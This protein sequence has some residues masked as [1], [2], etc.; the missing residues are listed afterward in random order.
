[1]DCA[2]TARRLT[3]GEVTVFYRRTRKEMPAQDEELCDLLDEGGQLVE[4]AAPQR[5]EV[6]EGRLRGVVM[7]KMEL[8][9]AD[10]S[11]RRRPQVMAG[12]EYGVELDTLIVA[13]GQQPDLGVFS[14]LEVALTSS[15]FLDVDNETLETS[16]PGVYAGGDII[17][18][19]PVSIVK[20]AGDG[21]RIAEA[22]LRGSAS[23]PAIDSRTPGAWPTFDRSE[24][25]R[26]RA[27]V[28]PRIAVPHLSPAARTGFDEVI[29][30][31]TPE[32]AALEAARCLDCDVLCSTC[33]G[34]CPNRAIITYTARPALL[35][36]PTLAVDHVGSQSSPVVSFK[37]AQ[38]P[39]V[40]VLADACN[41]CGNC[42]TFCPTSGRPWLDKP[43]LYLH[44]GDF[45]SQDDNAFMLVRHQDV[46]G[47]QGRFGG[48][49]HELFDGNRLRYT[50]PQLTVE[51]DPI[52]L[53]VH[54]TR[55]LRPETSTEEFDPEPLGAMITLLRSLTESMPE[56]PVVDAE[57]AWLI[58]STFGG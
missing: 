16:L 11:G 26:R 23:R 40:A 27:R 12:A 29:R 8:G 20:A 57:P 58:D 55:L 36:L 41:E 5:L 54:A 14:G 13:I 34:V 7:E 49:L 22:I 37:I 6:A 39:Q 50:C 24:M 10:P 56:L 51:L 44:R 38:G 43:R 52:T 47:L 9:A 45:E 2:R 35:E 42:V 25:M 31:L 17:G 18:T 1:M 53:R 21:R 28:A 46:R 48:E 15:G 32:N 4:L 33:E 19:G 30:T 3:D